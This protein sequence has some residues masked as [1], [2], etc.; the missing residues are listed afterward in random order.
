MADA[1]IDIVGPEELPAIVKLYNQIF[2]PARDVESF[3]RRYLGRHNVL[4]M[5]ARLDGRHPAEPFASG[6]ASQ[7]SAKFSPDGRWLAYCSNESGKPQAYVQAFP[8]P[9]PKIQVST[10]GGTDPV[11]KRTGGELYY[12]NGDSMMTVALSTASTF[13]AGRPQELWKGHYSHGMSSSCGAPGATSSNYDVTA[14]GKRFLMIKDDDQDR[15][16]SK[17]IVV[18]QGW[19]SELSRLSA[20]A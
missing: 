19:A 17:Q 11:W 12:R 15:A 3:Q 18:V 16:T 4:Q 14:D 1:L 6:K 7:G 8:G 9:G 2:R 13:S 20:K 10:E 5:V